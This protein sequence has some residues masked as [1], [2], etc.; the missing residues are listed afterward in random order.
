MFFDSKLGC[1]S[2]AIIRLLHLSITRRSSALCKTAI[3]PLLSGDPPFDLSPPSGR[4]PGRR[5]PSYRCRPKRAHQTCQAVIGVDG[6]SINRLQLQCGKAELD[7]LA[8]DL[9]GVPVPAPIFRGQLNAQL[10]GTRFR[11]CAPQAAATNKRL[12][13]AASND[14]KLIIEPWLRRCP[15][16]EEINQLLRLGLLCAIE[17]LRT[18]IVVIGRKCSDIRIIEITEQESIRRQFHCVL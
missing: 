15:C 17:L 6:V 16:S 12:R 8:H 13:F 2:Q 1:A 11:I 10:S 5:R 7:Q 4:H 9:D 14:C 3:L 18:R